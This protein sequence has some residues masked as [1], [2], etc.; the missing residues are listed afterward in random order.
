MLSVKVMIKGDKP[1]NKI[2]PIIKKS[3]FISL[4]LKVKVDPFMKKRIT[5]Q[6]KEA[7]CERMVASAA[8]STPIL[9]VK[10][11]KGS[12]ATFNKAP[13]SVVPIAKIEWP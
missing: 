10:I 13:K 1:K 12:S 4:S 5:I 9:K 6:T 8:P 7:N 11:N 2:D 3:N